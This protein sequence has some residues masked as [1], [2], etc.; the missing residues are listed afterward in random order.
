MSIIIAHSAN[1]GKL[2]HRCASTH[3]AKLRTLKFGSSPKEKNFLQKCIY[4]TQFRSSTVQKRYHF[5]LH[6]TDEELNSARFVCPAPGGIWTM[7]HGVRGFTRKID[8][9]SDLNTSLITTHNIYNVSFSQTL[10]YSP[11]TTEPLVM[12]I[13]TTIWWWPK[14]KKRHWRR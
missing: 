2:W 5:H 1:T 6:V 10:D 4:F 3:W 12:V 11:F 9:N 13:L 7:A 14:G 8:A